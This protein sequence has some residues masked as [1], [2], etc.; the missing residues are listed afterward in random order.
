MTK[1]TA[2]QRLVQLRSHGNLT[3]E[4][5]AKAV[6]VSRTAYVAWEKDQSSPHLRTRNRLDTYFA[7]ELPDH[8]K[9]GELLALWETAAIEPDSV[10]EPNDPP[11]RHVDDDALEPEP[12]IPTPTQQQPADHVATTTEPGAVREAGQ[13]SDGCMRTIG[14]RL[15]LLAASVVIIGGLLWRPWN[16][17]DNNRAYGVGKVVTVFNKV[18]LDEQNL[19]EDSPAYLSKRPVNFCKKL[20]CIVPNTEYGTGDQIRA[21]CQLQGEANTNRFGDTPN[22]DNFD[23]TLWYLVVGPDG[24][25]GYLSD[26]WINPTQRGGYE[27]P[28]CDPEKDRKLIG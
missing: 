21:L 5:V 4:A 27:L 12:D 18:V 8:Y 23:S 16:Q 17:S 6:D 19:R 13:D 22:K 25:T 9:T 7:T 10:V 26:V 24:H 20:G 14:V 15:V 11:C 1:L 28:A 2:G 3:Q